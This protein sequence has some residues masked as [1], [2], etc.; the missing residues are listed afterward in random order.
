MNDLEPGDV[1]Q[2]VHDWDNRERSSWH[3]GLSVD[4]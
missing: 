2:V 1:V 3:R 4:L